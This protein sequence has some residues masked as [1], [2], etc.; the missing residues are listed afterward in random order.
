MRII[1]VFFVQRDMRHDL[2]LIAQYIARHN[3]DIAVRVLQHSNDRAF[4]DIEITPTTPPFLEGGLYWP[5]G[6][7]PIRRAIEY[8]DF[9]F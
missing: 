4:V 8:S 6:T 9:G 1:V 3:Q 2:D 5:T 7:L